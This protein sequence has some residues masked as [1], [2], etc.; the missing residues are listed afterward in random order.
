LRRNAP[1]RFAGRYAPAPAQQSAQPTGRVET[2]KIYLDHD[3][4]PA[5]G[6]PIGALCK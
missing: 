4:R 6:R 2:K 3:Q 5:G 1:R